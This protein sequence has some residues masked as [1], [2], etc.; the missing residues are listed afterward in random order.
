LSKEP[1]G[2]YDTAG[3]LVAAF[4][5]ALAEM[6]TDLAPRGIPVLPDYTPPGMTRQISPH[7]ALTETEAPVLP[8]LYDAPSSEITAVSTPPPKRRPA[9][10]IGVGILL[11][12]ILCAGI[13]FLIVVNRQKNASSTAEVTPQSEI[14]DSSNA[15]NS[16]NPLQTQDNPPPN[17]APPAEEGG[18]ERPLLDNLNMPDIDQIISSQRIRPL[19]ELQKLHEENPQD[20]TIMMELAAAYMKA[21]RPDE[22]RE[23]VHSSLAQVRLPIG[24]VVTSE[25]LLENQQYEMA[26]LILEEG[27]MRFEDD[28]Y[29]QQMLMM[30]YLFSGKSAVE[31]DKY[32][33]R[34][35][36]GSHA[37]TTIHIGKAY[38]AFINGNRDEAFAIGDEALRDPK[39]IYAPDMLFVLGKFHLQQGDAKAAE[40]ALFNALSYEI[41]SWLA[42]HIQ[43]EIVQLDQP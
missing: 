13:I 34:L 29:M 36:K 16:Y 38:N 11:G 37:P 32:I 20:K 17:D 21:G 31:V 2:R 39:V 10:L 7:N 19:D 22:A 42:T 24:F 30:T 23:M 1:N 41:P 14:V 25:R 33:Q 6:S 26:E 9:A 35:G 27:L 5:A 43:A 12:M 40:E 28:Q 18:S 15:N 3:E 8:D 4:E